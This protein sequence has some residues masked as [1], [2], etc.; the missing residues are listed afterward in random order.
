M[1]AHTFWDFLAFLISGSLNRNKFH[2][3]DF[4]LNSRDE[5]HEF[6]YELHASLSE[7]RG[8]CCRGGWRKQQSWR[9]GHVLCVR[10]ARCAREDICSFVTR[11]NLLAFSSTAAKQPPPSPPPSPG[12]PCPPR[13][14]RLYYPPA[15]QEIA[16]D[17][18]SHEKISYWLPSWI[19]LTFPHLDQ[20]YTV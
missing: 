10:R 11:A 7:L 15:A 9:E 8:R 3:E 13:P 19:I 14:A 12:G 5:K 20:H 17:K 16:E 2:P 1:L 4:I 18:G 6:I